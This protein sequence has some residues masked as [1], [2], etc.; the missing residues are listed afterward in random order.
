MGNQLLSKQIEIFFYNPKNGIQPPND[1]GVLYLLRR[2]VYRCLG[3]NTDTWTIDRDSIIWPGT[4]T[5]LAGVDLL[6]KFFKGDDSFNGVGQRFMG[7]YDK[8]IDNKNSEIIYQF[9][10]SLLHSFG[11]LSKT[12]TK[13]YSFT[14]SAVRDRLVKQYSET[15]L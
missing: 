7:Y 14:V 1:Y 2:D 13:T 12:K 8:Y 3:Y 15:A 4:M 11:L 5:I 6:G 9:R 10:N